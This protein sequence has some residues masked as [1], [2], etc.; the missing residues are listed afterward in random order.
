[1]LGEHCGLERVPAVDLLTQIADLFQ[2][3]VKGMPIQYNI[4][5]AEKHRK[6]KD[7][8]RDFAVI[9]IKTVDVLRKMRYDV[10]DGRCLL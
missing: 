7:L 4:F 8:V 6:I 5:K 3:G 10:I 9:S 2:H 1:M